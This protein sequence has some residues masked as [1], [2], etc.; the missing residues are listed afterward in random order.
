MNATSFQRNGVGSRQPRKEDR[1]HLSG[2]GSFVADMKMTGLQEI[3]FLRSQVAHGTV[4]GVVLPPEAP[5]GS[6]WAAADLSGLVQDMVT[7]CE[8]DGYKESP[9]PA[10]ADEVVRYV[11]EPVALAIAPTRAEAEDLASRIEAEIEPLQIV[12]GIQDAL[13]GD[14]PPIHRGWS[15]HLYLTTTGDVGNVDEAKTRSELTIT[16]EFRLN[17]QGVLPLECRGIIAQY[18]RS[19]DQLLVWTGTQMPHMMRDMFASLLGLE[20]HRVRVIAPD[21]GGAFGAKC[22]VYADELAVAAVALQVDHPVRWIEDRWEA[23]LSTS[24]ARDQWFEITAHGTRDG[25]LLALEADIVTDSGAYS[26]HPWSATMDSGMSAAMVPGPY[27]VENYRF[28]ARSV[29]SNKT[30]SGPYRGVGRPG[31]CFAIE[32]TLDDFAHR[33]G[34]EP[35]E[36]RVRN[37]VRR[38]DMPYTSAGK[39]TYDSG[40]YPEA[41]RRAVALIDHD[42]WRTRQHEAS[43]DPHRRIGIGYGSFTEQTAHGCIEWASRG[44]ALTVGTEAARLSLDAGGTFTL[45]VGIKSH[46]QGSET[47]LA[48]VVSEVFDVGLD[49]ITVVHGDTGATPRGDGTFASR[50]MVMSGGATYHAASAL[51]EKVK[52]VGSVLLGE[53]EEN[54][55]FDSGEVVGEDGKVSLAELASVFLFQPNKVPGVEAGLEVTHF[56][57]PEVS[58]GAFTYATHAAVVEVDLHTGTV[59]LV[60]YAIVDDCGTIVNPLIVEGQ[61]IGGIAQG[62]GTALLEEMTYDPEGQPTSTTFLDYT[63]PTAPSIPEIKIEYMHTPSPNTVFGVKGAGEGG[64]I[65]PPAAIGNAITDAL[66]EFGARMTETPMTPARVWSALYEARDRAEEAR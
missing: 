49:K 38:Q 14:S 12:R 54:L 2:R 41:V 33:L 29:A 28:R 40:D 13:S 56:Y 10:L 16:R 60:D 18:D 19:A 43:R 55:Q 30:P 65:A 27:R 7:T 42:K 59:Q 47:T 6:V 48:Q 35:W 53:P 9:M 51:S 20:Q 64:I 24:Q 44:L 52:Q 25:R 22:S 39:K 26:L 3:A 57:Q 37:M 50:T 1:R 17:R 62:I 11:G 61:V 36:V 8:L 58:T 4:E 46:G 5:A 15:D 31:A 23:M 32:R 66:R 63:L 34:M 45:A 21:I